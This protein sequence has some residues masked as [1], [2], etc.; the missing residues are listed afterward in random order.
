M[1]NKIWCKTK[2][3]V[4]IAKEVNSEFKALLDLADWG[5]EEYKP[6]LLGVYAIERMVTE[7]KG[8][9]IKTAIDSALKKHD[10]RNLKVPQEVWDRFDKMPG[11]SEKQIEAYIVKNFVAKADEVAEE[12]LLKEA[13]RLVP[14][15]WKEGEGTAPCKA[16]ELVQGS[17]LTLNVYWSYESLNYDSIDRIRAL[18]KLMN[19]I[20]YGVPASK[21]ETLGLADLINAARETGQQDRTYTW[22]NKLIEKF[23]IYKNGK[24]EIKFK[25]ARNAKRIANVLTLK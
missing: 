10:V 19:V 5:K 2:R 9:L 11:F 21:A 14:W 13:K 4:A 12:Q 7:A 6:D 22:T 8:K 23:R 24:F 3:L 1:L 20:I 15:T 17:K 16:E 25:K 18:E